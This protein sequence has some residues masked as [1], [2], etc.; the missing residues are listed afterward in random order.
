MKTKLIA[1][2]AALALGTAM[3]TN[4][5]AFRHGGGRGFHGGGGVFHGGMGGAHVGGFPRSRGFGGWHGGFGGV[6]ARDRCGGSTPRGI[7]PI[8]GSCPRTESYGASSSPPLR[9]S[10]TPW[11]RSS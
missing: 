10:I 3:T 9:A 5:M 8:P 2:V 4:A 1:V 11:R 6:L 7:A